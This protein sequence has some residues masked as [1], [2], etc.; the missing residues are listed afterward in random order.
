MKRLMASGFTDAIESA[1]A[2][3]SP[4]MLD[5]LVGVDFFCGVAPSYVGLRPPASYKFADGRVIDY[6]DLAH[7][8]YPHHLT[9]LPVAERATTVALPTWRGYPDPPAVVLHELGHALHWELDFEPD[10]VPVTEYAHEN[11]REAF[12]EAF[13]AWAMQSPAFALLREVDPATVAL[14]ER[15]SA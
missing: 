7:T 4:R 13:E 10:A 9:H 15:L 12:A 2:R 11:R 5:R 1:R 3:L 8:I 6:A 14:F